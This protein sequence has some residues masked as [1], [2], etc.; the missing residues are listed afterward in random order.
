MFRRCML[1]RIT[2]K[3]RSRSVTQWKV[4]IL[5]GVIA[6]AA[7]LLAGCGGLEGDIENGIEI[8]LEAK[9][10]CLDLGAPPYIAYSTTGDLNYALLAAG[11]AAS[12]PR[13]GGTFEMIPSDKGK[14]LIKDN[15]LCYGE[16]RLL[17]IE[18]FT[19]PTD[20]PLGRTLSAD[21]RV[22]YDITEKWARGDEFAP[23]VRS[24]EDTISMSLVEKKSGWTPL[25]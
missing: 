21:V 11:F 19:L 22:R 1:A 24:G 3:R 14:K 2:S 5:W 10:L 7:T 12:M 8:A 25:Y 18:D 23:F 20:T 4:A 13:A 16:I 6:T 15:R 9:P 17:G